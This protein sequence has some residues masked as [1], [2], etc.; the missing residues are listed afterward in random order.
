LLKFDGSLK[1]Y[2]YNFRGFL[3]VYRRECVKYTMRLR[4]K[5]VC[6]D[7]CFVLSPR[8]KFPESVKIWNYLWYSLDDRSMEGEKERV[9]VQLCETQKIRVVLCEVL[10][11]VFV[12]KTCL[13]DQS[14]D[15]IWTPARTNK[16]QLM[17]CV[18]ILIFEVPKSIQFFRQLF[19][20]TQ[21]RER[22]F[23]IW[24]F[25]SDLGWLIIF[26]FSDSIIFFLF[27]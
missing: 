15:T 20:T 4:W 18:Y 9:N 13:Y 23:L 19:K 1:I 5:K 6:V 16:L 26:F 7:F 17:K 27:S 14:E 11:E 25:F 10:T 8:D 12:L 3:C 22:E 21:R 2:I 24:F